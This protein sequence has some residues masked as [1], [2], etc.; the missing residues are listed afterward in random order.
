MPIDVR[1]PSLGESISEATVLEWL[2]E[3]GQAVAVDQDLV[4]L[5]TDKITVNVPAPSAGVLTE[6][7]V[8]EGDDVEVGAVIAR[9]EPGAAT[10]ETAST[11]PATKAAT[12]QAATRQPVTPK[13]P[14]ADPPPAAAA[15]P[16]MPAVRR[17][18]ADQGL[19]PARIR[20]T[21][22]GGRILKEDVLRH[23][24][25]TAAPATAA[26][27]RPAAPQSAPASAARP[28]PPPVMGEGDRVVPMSKLRRRIAE[29]L[30]AA[31]REAAMLTT[32]NE[33]DMSAVM[34][35]RKQYQERFKA[36]YDI[37][38]GFMSFFAKAS[39]E[40]LKDF[41]SVNAEVS[42]DNILYR[43]RYDIGVAVGGGRGLVVPVIRAVDGLGM[44]EFELALADVA[45][46]ARDNKLTMADLTGGT[47]T[48]SNGGIYGSLLSTPILN[49]PQSG[50][51][52]LHKIEQ[53]PIALDGAVVIRPMMYL[54]L[55]YDHR[56]I[57]GREAVG[58]LVRIK[59]I[60]EDPTRLLIEV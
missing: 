1:V 50:I 19:D 5:E 30:V 41:P 43:S 58:F 35:L 23:I 47:F 8:A 17:L 44:A 3:P 54:A 21:G 53:R 14:A 15:A 7:V 38:L 37:K 10:S 48:I 45:R 20:G 6:H 29:N 40:A 28:T 32:F 33:V 18:I 2:V 55:T 56:I 12:P 22:R 16:L 9:L 46:R 39:V 36:R 57:D 24:A 26:A 31:Q 49:R 13:P 59:E 52:G 60:I 42:G 51:L 34:A 11:A 25:G 4:A 27:P